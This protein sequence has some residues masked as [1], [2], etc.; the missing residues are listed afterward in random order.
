MNA[1]ETG[2][3]ETMMRTSPDGR[4]FARLAAL[5]VSLAMAASAALRA[6]PQ[7]SQTFQLQPGWNAIYLEVRPQ[8]NDSDSV[9]GGLPLAS[10][11]T[12]NPEFP[13]P[14]FIEDPTEELIASPAWQGY[15]PQPRPEAVL[16]N[17]FAVLPN[18]AYLLK[19]DGDEPVNWTVHG[20]PEITRTTWGPD[21]FNLVGFHVDPAIPPTFATFLAPSPAHAGQPVFRL[22][23]GSWQ[24]ANPATTPIR[25]G[26]S[27][28]VYCN[29][30]SDYSGPL[31]ID[32]DTGTELAFGGA[33]GQAQIRVRN[34]A[35]IPASIRL[36]QVSGAAPLPLQI[37]RFDPDT[38]DIS[39]PLLPAQRVESIG[40]RGELLVN[41]APKRAQ[42]TT[43]IAELILE[44]RDGFGYKRAI[45]VSAKT[46]FAPAASEL[47]GD[48]P[49]GS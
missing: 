49:E 26:E 19:I 47:R 32:L 37:R 29:G 25:S 10:A 30:A 22:V 2:K 5:A 1:G 21:A 12:W 35:P 28:W 45:A 24:Q 48:S 40:E 36:T 31:D 38:G 7:T 9:F 33:I 41:L 23:D 14:K 43:D 42:F 6:E 17:L 11:W 13:R 16:T 15:F 8:P 18:R 34:L 44:V 3:K 46:A 4:R 20:K 27:Y 39:W